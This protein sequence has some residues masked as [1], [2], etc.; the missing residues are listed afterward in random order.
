VR[1]FLSYAS[2]RRAAAEPIAFAL[3]G[4]GHEVFFDK[5]DLPPAGN[6]DAQI[7]EAIRRSDLMIFLISPES[8]SH[9][10]FTLTELAF[11]RKKWPSARGRVVPVIIAPTPLN[12]VPAYLTSVHIM[13]PEGNAAAEVA[14]LVDGFTPVAKAK[15]ILPAALAMGVLSGLLS[16]LDIPAPLATATVEG[17]PTFL[18]F[19]LQSVLFLPGGMPKPGA[20]QAAYLFAPVFIILLIFWDKV[21]PWRS[22]WAFP[23]IIA[24]WAAAFWLS[25]VLVLAF[26]QGLSAPIAAQCSGNASPQELCSEIDKYREQISPLMSRLNWL[27]YTVAGLSGGFV[28]SLITIVGLGRLSKRLRPLD[29]VVLVVFVGTLAGALLNHDL[30]IHLDEVE[31]RVLL[32]VTWQAAVA[33][34]IAW[35]FTKAPR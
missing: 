5:I 33:M 14:S 19:I 11:A 22:V 25:Y 20:W 31:A 9:E 17:L 6:Y 30:V 15:I 18:R 7:E 27:V 29:A 2:E 8:V 21:T 28:G 23:I 1:I 10:R 26:G 3:R 12:Q 34:A 16:G 4:R 35:Q 13:E 32:Y 24:A